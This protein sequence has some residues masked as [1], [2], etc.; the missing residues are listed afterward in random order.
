MRYKDRALRLMRKADALWPLYKSLVEQTRLS[1]SAIA[2]RLGVAWDT[3]KAMEEYW[4]P[5]VTVE[6]GTEDAG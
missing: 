5:R 6:R 3:F 2:A 1:R 4:S